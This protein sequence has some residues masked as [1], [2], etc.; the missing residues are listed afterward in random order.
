MKKTTT[1]LA[2]AIL[3]TAIATSCK[4]NITEGK[5]ETITDAR[6]ISNFTSVA[7][8]VSVNANIQVTEG[9]AA[10]VELKG[11]ANILKNIK[12]E[13]KNGKL[14]ISSDDLFH[15]R[16][17]RDI[18]ANIVVPSLSLLEINGAGDAKVT[19][20]VKGDK[21]KV[22]VSGAGD[23]EI[24][25]IIA[26]T[27]EADLSG[28]G[29]LKIAQGTVTDSRLEVTGVGDIDA[30]GLQTQNTRAEVTGAGEVHVSAS[31]KLVAEVTGAGDIKYKGQPQVTSDI[32][33]AGSVE[34]AK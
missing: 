12:T 3:T 30:F 14:H 25:N 16:T 28:A 31:Q 4:R 22:E 26:N 34:E 10:S 32:T 1:L 5:G 18:V 7:L 17:D 20:V 24:E 11:Y 8:D 2:A 33:G 9:A 13:V 19:G 27:F 21:F 23:V 15:F 6:S 29:D